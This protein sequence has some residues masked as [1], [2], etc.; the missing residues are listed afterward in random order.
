MPD[1]SVAHLAVYPVKSCRGLPQ[2]R[3]AVALT[4]LAIAGV[5]DREWMVVDARGRFVTQRE[6]PRLALIEPRVIDGGIE[7]RAP[8]MAAVAAR[9]SGA[10]REVVVWSAHVRGFDAGDEVASSL[11][12][13]LG[14]AVRL[15]RF[16]DS[17]PRPCNP[18]FAGDRGA[19]VLFNDGYPILV[20]GKASLDDLN[21]RL[22][23][24]GSDALP[25]DRFRPNLVLDGL[26]PY[27]EDHLESI[28]IGEV[29]LKPVKP[30]TRCEITTTDQASARR[31][32]EPLRTLSTYRRDDR[33]AGVTFGMNAI[34]VAGA[35]REI[36][37][38]DK[39]SVAFSF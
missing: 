6:R 38:G 3:A 16:D 23:D 2:S 37:V 33:L 15:V 7:L 14:Q 4:G 20:I 9:A 25:M 11:S 19:A 27:D 21:D 32:I 12:T 39:A 29:V 1:A 22:G 34:V 28:A 18:A 36:A 17:H 35:G 10:S 26:E 8:G 30:C 13:F 31:G 24:R 5:R